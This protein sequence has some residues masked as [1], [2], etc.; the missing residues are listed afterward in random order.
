[1][2]RAAHKAVRRVT[3]DI[4]SFKFNTAVAA[5]ME[6]VNT[7]WDHLETHGP[8]HAFQAA[9]DV[10]VRLLA[11]LAPHIAE[12][13]WVRRGGRFSVHQQPWPVYDAAL[14]VD[15]TVTLVIQINGKV[16]D[17]VDVPV[18][19]GDAEAQALALASERV[20]HYL[21][22]RQPKQVVVV[23]GRLVNVVV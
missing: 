19:I 10:L 20:R 12:E 1:M 2:T 23:P 11:P 7:L 13:L 9:T 21:D 14:T 16:R 6:F 4:E 15:E 8:S 22:C 17:R 5:M 18:G 3:E